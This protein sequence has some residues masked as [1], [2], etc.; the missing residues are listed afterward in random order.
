MNYKR[1]TQRTEVIREERVEE[2]TPELVVALTFVIDASGSMAGS[3]MNATIT[4]MKHIFDNLNPTDRV[5]VKVFND[6][7]RDIMGLRMK[8][9]VR[10]NVLADDIRA[11]VGGRTAMRDAILSAIETINWGVNVDGVP[12]QREIVVFTDGDD[13]RSSVSYQ[14]LKTVMHTMTPDDGKRRRKL[15]ITL[16]GCGMENTYQNSLRRLC[17]TP[18]TQYLPCSAAA[19]AIERNFQSIQQNITTRVITRIQIITEERIRGPQLPAPSQRRIG[20]P[21]VSTRATPSNL[22]STRSRA[23][24][25]TRNAGSNGSSTQTRTGR[26][27]RRRNNRNVNP[28]VHS[29][30][31][32]TL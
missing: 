10:W 3:R 7:V 18:D 20:L 24:N 27:S 17:N 14:R 29:A 23:A 22:G 5:A 26:S 13:N 19:D 2:A 15:F 9:T 12:S 31:K 6:E 8:S 16:I 28:S 21:P 4:G 11:S 25:T 30:N 1:V 32:K